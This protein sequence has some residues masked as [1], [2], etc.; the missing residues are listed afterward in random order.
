MALGY[1]L[2][3]IGVGPLC[4]NSEVVPQGLALINLVPGAHEGSCHLSVIT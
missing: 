1:Y 4:Q 2:T 3:I